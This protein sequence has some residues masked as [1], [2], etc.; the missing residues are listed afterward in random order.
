MLHLRGEKYSKGVVA[1]APILDYIR[2][3]AVNYKKSE[4]FLH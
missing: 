3:D 4:A 2:S 1:T